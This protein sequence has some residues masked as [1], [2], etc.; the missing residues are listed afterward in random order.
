MLLFTTQTVGTVQELLWLMAQTAD[1]EEPAASV[2]F[3]YL[4]CSSGV[5][6]S[7]ALVDP[8]G[9]GNLES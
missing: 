6:V 8:V 5:S 3:V 1:F 7:Q 2:C 4:F 9:D